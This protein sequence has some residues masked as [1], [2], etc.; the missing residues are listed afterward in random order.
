MRN[1]KPTNIVAGITALAAAVWLVFSL[2]DMPP[3]ADLNA[4][5]AAGWALGEETLALLKP[6]GH[7][8]V[9]TWDTA[10]FAHPEADA[11]LKSFTRTL[12]KSNV[13]IESV[14][15]LQVDPLRPI[16][17]PAGDFFE[18]IRTA[19]SGSVIVSFLGPPLLNDDQ[20][21]RLGDVK[22]K[23][24]ALCPGA[25]PAQIDLRVLF[26]AGILHAAVVS[27]PELAREHS[28]PGDPRVCFEKHYKR[29][30]A[31]DVASLY[32]SSG[33]RRANP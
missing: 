2:A 30:T 29:V 10:S 21:S 5:R 16:E 32:M 8:T 7:V 33:E 9:I 19:S 11:L 12:R 31:S 14:H 18:F 3:G 27:N 15:Q 24:V 28:D 17:V 13:E 22:P 23:I 4:P 6:G 25:L 20:R 1:H 26:Q